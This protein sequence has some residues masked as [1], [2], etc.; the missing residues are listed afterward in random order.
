[1]SVVAIMAAIGLFGFLLPWEISARSTPLVLLGIATLALTP[2]LFWVLGRRIFALLRRAPPMA[3]ALILT[4]GLGACSKVPVGNVGIKVNNLG[5]DKGVNDAVLPVGWYWVGLT[6]SLYVFPTYMQN[7]VWSTNPH[8]G[9]ANDESISFQTVEGLSV[10]ADIGISYHVDPAKVPLLFQTYRTGLREITDVYLRNIVRDALVTQAST[11][12]IES[13]YGSGKAD[14][15]KKVQ[16]TVEAKVQPL[17]ILIDQLSWVGDLRLPRTVTDA[18]NSKIQAT[19]QA[20]QRE[21]EVAT[22]KAQAQ[23]EVAEA[24]GHAQSRLLEAQAEAQANKTIA[25]SLTPELVQYE[26]IQKMERCI[27]SGHRPIRHSSFKPG[28]DRQRQAV[29]APER[30]YCPIGCRFCGAGFMTGPLPG[31]ITVPT[32]A[33]PVPL[34]P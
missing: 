2:P 4:L 19:Q 18:I 23:K 7:Y 11:Q 22:A 20:Q 3:L 14:L 12:P 6:K 13:V 32:G 21:N 15:I 33:V 31:T 17:G 16:Q 1:M 27:A 9:S 26:T 5:G 25:E 24:T 10:N 28:N 34:L 8:E 30:T 29:A